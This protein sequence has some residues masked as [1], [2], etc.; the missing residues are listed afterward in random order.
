MDN[1]KVGNEE[2]VIDETNFAEHFH[3]ARRF[4]PKPGEVLAK[5]RAVAEFVDGKGKQDI[6]YLLKIGKAQQAAE[7]MKKIHGALEPDC[8]R[9]CREICVDLL[10]MSEEEVEKK[11]YEYQL[12]FLY[13]TKREFVPKSDP[14]WELIPLLKVDEETGHLKSVIEL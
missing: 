3:D 11:P 10:S 7:V 14:R 12:E 8:Y 9:V 6:I 4:A 2:L 1:T 5:F 13:Y